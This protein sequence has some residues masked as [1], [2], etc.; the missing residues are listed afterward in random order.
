LGVEKRGR[1]KRCRLEVG[2][3]RRRRRILDRRVE[4]K[5]G[6]KIEVAGARSS[7]RRR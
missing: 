5:I 4:W 6:G 2:G 7:V 3:K 1:R